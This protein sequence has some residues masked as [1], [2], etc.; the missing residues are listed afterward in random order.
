MMQ[1]NIFYLSDDMLSIRLNTK[2]VN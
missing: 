2:M 1:M